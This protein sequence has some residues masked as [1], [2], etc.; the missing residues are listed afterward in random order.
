MLKP[1]E[2]AYR[3]SSEDGKRLTLRPTYVDERDKTQY[4]SPVGLFAC[5]DEEHAIS[6]S[7]GP[8]LRRYKR[9]LERYYEDVL[10][11]ITVLARAG[12]TVLTELTE[13]EEGLA[14]LELL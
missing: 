9:Q 7:Q 4:R 8:A 1:T 3:I 5:S 6:I 13:L 10:V 11:R 2:K 14:E 12:V